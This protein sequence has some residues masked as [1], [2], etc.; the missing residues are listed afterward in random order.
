[1]ASFRMPLLRRV[2]AT[3]ALSLVALAFLPRVADAAQPASLRLLGTDPVYHSVVVTMPDGTRITGA[4]G[5]FRLRITPAAGPAVERAGFCVDELHVIAR[6]VDYPV[7][8][9]TAADDARLATPRYAEAAWLIQSADGLIAAAAPDKRA[10]EAGALQAAVWQLTG[11]AREVNPTDDAAL[12]ARTAALRALAA[13]RAI[14]GPLTITPA[15][16]RGCAGRSSVA[17][18]LTGTPGSSATLA[19]TGG[20][21]TVSPAT[22]RFGADGTAQAAVTSA[23]PGT[24]AVTARAEGGALTRIAPAHAGA[25]TPQETMVL[26]PQ[27]YSATASVLFDDCPVVPFEE[28]NTPTTP[29]TPTIP[30][31]PVS[32]FEAPS[33]K[34]STP[35]PSG[36]TS[37]RTPS[38]ATPRFGVTKSGPATARAG[39]VVRY[40]I[41]VVNRG[42]TTL[43]DLTLSDDLPQG[44]SLT[45]TPAGSRLRAGSLVWSLA[46]LK[47]GARRSLRVGVRLDA[48]IAGRRCNRATVTGSGGQRST[49]TAC[50]VVK[51]VPR[52]ILPAVT[53]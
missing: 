24:V 15:M 6:N 29:A 2:A 28:G 3:A 41:T 16:T 47:A 32:P 12:D 46:P 48:D 51:A 49:A 39:A 34:P 42:S 14:G 53:A 35:T 25:G 19:V 9:Q 26:D 11:Q 20:S 44:M 1:M 10:L 36:R 43:R 22:V 23:T 30:S 13:G 31:I 52:A 45:A 21:G 27:T 50:T 8:L 18:N 17:L 38:Q 5:L 37:P 40:T 33:S 7:S 4:P